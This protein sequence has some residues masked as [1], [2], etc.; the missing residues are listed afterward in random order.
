MTAPTS[1]ELH[2]SDGRV[3]FD[4]KIGN[5][6]KAHRTDLELILKEL[7]Y[8]LNEVYCQIAI[9]KINEDVERVIE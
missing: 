5:I 7:S 1:I 3:K 4:H 6:D 9:I 2:Y 8:A